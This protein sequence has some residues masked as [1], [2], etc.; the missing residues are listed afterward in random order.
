M[1]AT[2]VVGITQHIGAYTVEK[3]GRPI[4]TPGPEAFT[5]M[6]DRGA[7]ITDLVILLVS[8]DD[9]DDADEADEADDADDGVMTQTLEAISDA[10]AAKVPIILLWLLINNK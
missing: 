10:Q 7:N 2:E 5:K 8:V 1:V 9:A 4:D 3:N 6:L